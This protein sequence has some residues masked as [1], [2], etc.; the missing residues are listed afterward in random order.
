M[1]LAHPRRRSLLGE[2]F[3]FW[4]R[5]PVWME[6]LEGRCVQAAEGRQ[7]PAGAGSCRPHGLRWP[8]RAPVVAVQ[9]DKGGAVSIARGRGRRGTALP[10]T[11]ENQWPSLPSG[12]RKG[13]EEGRIRGFSVWL[14]VTVGWD[15][16]RGKEDYLDIRDCE[17]FQECRYTFKTLFSRKH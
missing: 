2:G 8:Q 10:W 1:Q 17:L 4:E 14:K 7:E 12:G 3:C 11:A 6:E 5:F 16:D 15:T 9:G 13:W